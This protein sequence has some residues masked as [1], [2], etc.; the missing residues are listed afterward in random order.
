[1]ARKPFK[2]ELQSLIYNLFWCN[3]NIKNLRQELLNSK[4]EAELF[5]L[6]SNLQ[7]YKYRKTYFL[8]E[9]NKTKKRET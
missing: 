4:D 6:N 9:L 5:L 3:R 1:M 7:E 2:T 8:R